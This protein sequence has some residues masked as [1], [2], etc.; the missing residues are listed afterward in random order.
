MHVHSVTAPVLVAAPCGSA[1]RTRVPRPDGFRPPPPAM[2]PAGSPFQKLLPLANVAFSRDWGGSA[3]LRP[4]GLCVP[5][6]RAKRKNTMQTLKTITFFATVSN[7]ASSRTTKNGR[8]YTAFGGFHPLRRPAP[9]LPL[10][11]PLPSASRATSPSRC[12]K[13]T[14]IKL[15]IQAQSQ[16]DNIASIPLLTATFVRPVRPAAPTIPRAA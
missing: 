2:M 7:S 12:R 14:R 8:D 4:F 16:P 9:D 6:D 5:S 11:R 13:A 15:V 3:P 10:Q 1:F